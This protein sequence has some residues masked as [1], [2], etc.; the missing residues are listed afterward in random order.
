MP[1]YEF[2]KKIPKIAK[3]SY[4]HP[5]AVIIGDVKIGD[6]CFIAA[7]AVL[8]GDFGKI[9]IGSGTSVQ[10]NCTIHVTEGKTVSIHHH[11]IVAHGAILHDATV[12]SYVLVGMGAILMRG[13]FCEDHVLIAAGSMV[14]EGFYIPSNVVVAGNPARIVKPLSAEQRK[15]IYQGVKTYQD[16][17]KR[18][19]RACLEVVDV[20]TP[21][22]RKA[23]E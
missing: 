19:R 23:R 15:A 3:T 13:V 12:K 22:K 9:M 4:V 2:E 20:R 18:Y 17:V 5:E 14:K 1:I 7:G 8:R 11:V 21:P 10:E 6:H 16:L